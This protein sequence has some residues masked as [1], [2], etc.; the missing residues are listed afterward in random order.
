V[1]QVRRA[2]REDAA[3]GEFTNWNRRLGRVLYKG[4]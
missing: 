3:E 2:I 4:T 1:N